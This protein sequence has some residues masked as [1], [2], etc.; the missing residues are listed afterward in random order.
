MYFS[1]RVKSLG[2]KICR[3]S[4]H[5]VLACTFAST[6]TRGREVQA[7]VDQHFQTVGRQETG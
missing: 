3:V 6:S 7:S 1:S 5:S 2:D 4:Q